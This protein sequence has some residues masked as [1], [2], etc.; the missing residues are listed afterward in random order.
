MTRLVPTLGALVCAAT[1]APMAAADGG[2]VCA[3]ATDGGLRV[4]IFTAPT[5]L[6]VGTAEIAV[7]VQDATDDSPRMDAAV[8]LHLTT[9]GAAELVTV[10]AR[11]GADANRLL[12]AATVTLPAA[13][14]I[15]IEA[16]VDGS[17]SQARVGCR[18][19]VTEAAPPL[20]SSWPLLL[21]PPVAVALFAA[22][23]VLAI[24][25]ERRRSRPRLPDAGTPYDA[26]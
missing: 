10:E 3:S 20:L 8:Q 21:F 23:Q 25:Q 19:D 16:Q 24:R 7:L 14:P 15:E 12:R 2:H 6:R 17:S 5:P 4:T 13:G 9:P 18:T 11:A 26:A 1:L 22:R